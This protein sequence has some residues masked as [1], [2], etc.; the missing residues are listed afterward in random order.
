MTLSNTCPCMFV[1]YLLFAKTLTVKALTG[2]LPWKAKVPNNNMSETDEAP[3]CNPWDAICYE[4]GT[5]SGRGEV[6][7]ILWC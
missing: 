2:S 3:W 1:A 4:C 6:K 7:N 5:V